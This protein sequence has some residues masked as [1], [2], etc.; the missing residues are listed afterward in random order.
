MFSYLRDH[1]N[2]LVRL[3][4]I[5][6]WIILF[7]LTSLPTGLAIETKDVSDKVLHFG[8]YGLLSVFLYLNLYFQN[9]SDVLKSYAGFFTVIIASFYGVL[10]EIHQMLVPGRSTEFFDW[11]ADFTGSLTAVL[12]TKYLIVYLINREAEKS[13]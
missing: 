3:P 8:A 9:K 5:L 6:Y 7:I 11:L 4:L 1:K 10:D 2:Y 12:I 13:K